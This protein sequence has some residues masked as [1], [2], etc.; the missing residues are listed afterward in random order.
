[1]TFLPRWLRPL[2][3]LTL[4]LV[5]YGAA[6]QTPAQPTWAQEDVPNDASQE[7]KPIQDEPQIPGAAA[8]QEARR[9]L[10]RAQSSH[11]RISRLHKRSGF[12]GSSLYY[13]TKILK[14]LFLTTPYTNDSPQSGTTSGPRLNAPLENAV[15]LLEGAASDGNA[16]AHYIL[17]EMSFYGTHGFS[18]NYTMAYGHY[19][20]LADT[21]GNSTAQHMVGF[22]YAT[23]LGNV[24]EKDQAK[25]FL[26]HTFAAEGGDTRS[27]MTT[28]Y[29]HHSGVATPYSCEK[30]VEYYKRVADKAIEY[31]RSGPPG[32]RELVREYYRFA[33]D[34]GGVYGEGASV[35]SSGLNA[36]IRGLRTHAND[37]YLEYL[38]LR[39]R[40][41]EW[42]AAF[43]LAELSYYGSRHINQDFGK[44]KGLFKVVAQHYWFKDGKIRPDPDHELDKYAAKSAGYLGRM[45]L[46]GEGGEQSY[47]KA[48]IW[49]RRGIE[50][51]DA[52]CQ[53]SMGLMQLYGLEMPGNPV[54]AAEFFGAAADQEH[55]PAQ[56]RLGALMMDQG[57]IKT[58][59]RYFDLAARTGNPEA[60][61]YLAEMHDLG[62]EKG[63]S[64][65]TATV[66]YKMV[67]EKAE[68]LQSMFPE[69]NEAYQS[70]DVETALLLYMM[71]A[72]QGYEVAQAN[73]AYMLD[74]HPRA[75]HAI[76]ALL[77][78]WLSRHSERRTATKEAHVASTLAL[79][80]WTRS[81]KQ[82][83]I[84]SLLKMG[85]YYLS[86][87]GV[88]P[89][90]SPLPPHG[91][92][93][94][95]T[96][97]PSNPP[98]SEEPDAS[99]DQGSEQPPPPSPEKPFTDNH[100]QLSPDPEKAAACYS[101]ATESPRLSAQ[102]LWN[103][104]WMHENGL[105]G[106]A[107]DF[108]LAKRYYD[109]SL[110]V[111]R[112]AY[113]PVLLA[114]GKLRLRSAWNTI[115]GGGAG[116]LRDED[117]FYPD[118]DGSPAG[119]DTGQGKRQKPNSWAE[120][121][122]DFLAA[123]LERYENE[124][125]Q[126]EHQREQQNG[127]TGVAEIDEWDI[128]GTAAGT[129][130]QQPRGDA[131]H[132]AVDNNAR[133]EFGR[134]VVRRAADDQGRW[135]DGYGGGG[136]G[137]EEQPN[138]F[139]N[140]YEFVLD[141]ALV[142]TALILGLAGALA[143]L[144]WWRQARR[145]R[146]GAEPRGR[147]RRDGDA[148]ENG[149]PGAAGDANP[150]EALRGLRRRGQGVDEA[151]AG[152]EENANGNRNDNANA[153]FPAPGDPARVEWVAGGVGH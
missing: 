103:L 89:P 23:G 147:E 140:V 127:R 122:T 136:V 70:G 58:A 48:K 43:T 150:N 30:A 104:G 44:A 100:L 31:V 93:S 3:L 22:L 18:R 119:E 36:K 69:A 105:G 130:M 90:S 94:A 137:G 152:R 98:D 153:M 52:L 114:L 10:R 101:A 8:V 72:E 84:D 133:D 54:R 24:V 128:A 107:Q 21:L 87:L 121:L 113:L 80:Y 77:P 42:L 149:A 102:A 143:G 11:R 12:L 99:T 37:D 71:A 146:E 95:P 38:E 26:Y 148:G 145:Q 35:S 118:S 135:F 73:V 46:R 15:K 39:V 1:M 111:N 41:G 142:D 81:A 61:Y 14:V 65:P 92:P 25:A 141:D 74:N 59:T 117:V 82:S 60:L 91:G 50:N 57:D 67:A 85:D 78:E 51:G 126:A 68:A 132:A 7:Q 131:G 110:E 34:E 109:Q 55:S 45:F 96:T 86:G 9:S 53:Y 49:F 4:F 115:T 64:C 28:A 134:P 97:P 79:T 139:Q 129:G 125:A 13:T 47:H 32:G 27:E 124:A 40:K 16:D 29:R 5:S 62:I 17:A 63:K 20:T 106:L 6:E 33:D 83:N 108:H 2:L 120:W 66:Y 151:G 88:Y 76:L 123:D 112:E 116:S 75:Y 19:K 56:V 138:D 144:V